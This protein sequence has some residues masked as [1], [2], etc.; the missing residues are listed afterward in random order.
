MRLE[1]RVLLVC[2][3]FFSSCAR[4][5][6]S[7]NHN[8]SSRI[9]LDELTFNVNLGISRSN[10]D[11]DLELGGI[12]ID[13]YKNDTFFSIKKYY[14][15]KIYDTIIL[16]NE[17]KDNVHK[18]LLKSKGEKELSISVMPNTRDSLL[19]GFNLS[20]IILQKKDSLR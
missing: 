19:F 11:K 5:N 16:S 4:D 20:E 6:E 10:F 8:Y 9:Q 12:Y 2:L 13:V 17:F 18:Y 14:F 7:K 1:I 15:N 3:F